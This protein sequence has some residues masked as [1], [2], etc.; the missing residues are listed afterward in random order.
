MCEEGNVRMWE[1]G[2]SECGLGVECQNMVHQWSRRE[3]LDISFFTTQN[4]S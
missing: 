3:S 1:G 2:M 4:R